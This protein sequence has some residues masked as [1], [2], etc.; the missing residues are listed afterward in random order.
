MK[1]IFLTSTLILPKLAKKKKNYILPPTQISKFFKK[2]F[3]ILKTKICFHL[4][5]QISDKAKKNY[6]NFS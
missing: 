3:Q 2:N 1:I 4:H 5:P 6:P